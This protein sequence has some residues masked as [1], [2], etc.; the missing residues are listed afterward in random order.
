MYIARQLTAATLQEIGLE[1]GGKHHTTA[2]H[3]INKIDAMRS[4]GRASDS[5]I[6]RL[7]DTEC[8]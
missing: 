3:A 4:S 6:M 5:T 1:F 7:M 2:L 8:V